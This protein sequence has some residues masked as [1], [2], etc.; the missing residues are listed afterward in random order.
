VRAQIG[1]LLAAALALSSGFFLWLIACTLW[2]P[3]ERGLS[4]L[5][6]IETS[7]ALWPIPALAIATR[8]AFRPAPRGERRAALYL[9]TLFLTPFF[10]CLFPYP[11]LYWRVID[12]IANRRELA[13]RRTT[14]QPVVDALASCLQHEATPAGDPAACLNRI[15]P[16]PLPGRG[17]NNQ[18][19]FV[20]AREGFAISAWATPRERE[21]GIGSVSYSSLDRQWRWHD[22]APLEAIRR[23]AGDDRAKHGWGCRFDGQRWSCS[24]AV[25]P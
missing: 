19:R 18:L 16:G 11:L 6:F 10:T 21:P 9:L 20:G 23:L 22:S 5:V 2:F 14:L 1:A 17:R 12:P 15:S 3:D 4:D 24:E 25:D 13:I 8:V 7:L